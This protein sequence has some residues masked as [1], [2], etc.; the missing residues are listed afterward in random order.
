MGR[1]I[2]YIT[3]I[4]IVQ[5]A[6][7]APTLRELAS[8]LGVYMGSALNQGCIQNSSDPNYA[9]ISI[10]QYDLVT[11]ENECKFAPTEP[12][13]GVFDFEGCDF[14]TNFMI[15]NGSGVARGHNMV[16]GQV[17]LLAERLIY[18]ACSE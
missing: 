11:A 6:H 13:Q 18:Q 4:C 8:K 16:W 9:A 3:A 5:V 15:K 10:Q 14:V 12:S 1:L 7:G 2:V 17:R